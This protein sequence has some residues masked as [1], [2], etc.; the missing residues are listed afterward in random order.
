MSKY[1]DRKN[2][3][4]SQYVGY[5]AFADAT[6]RGQIRAAVDAGSTI[7]ANWDVMEG[8]LDYV[9]LK[10]GIDQEASLGGVGRPVVMTEP[11]ANLPYC[12]RMMNEL[13][14]ECYAAPSVAYGID[15][16]F[17]YRQ[18]SGRTGLV[19]SSS[20]S[21]THLIPVIDSRPLLGLSSRLNWGGAQASE[22]LLKLLKLKYPSFPD[23][24]T[25]VAAQNMVRE[26]CYVARDYDAELAG[27]L[28]WEGLEHR[29]RVVQYPYTEPVVVEKTPEELA[30]IAERKRESGRRL[31]EQ[32]AKM[33]LE[34][35]LKKERELEYYKELQGS[36]AGKPK[37]E[38]KRVLDAEDLRDEA[39]LDRVVYE[40][41][42]SIKRSRTR[43]LG[44]STGEDGGAAEGG[45]APG[46]EEGQEPTF[47]L[48]DTP[49]EE[50]DEAGVREKRH[51]PYGVNIVK[52][53]NRGW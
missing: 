19:L 17:A 1:R 42:R 9:F 53:N 45:G 14:F 23:K 46:S 25:D 51:Q 24:V 49:D 40:L 35:L 30:R 36:L 33:R 13:L 32:A 6:V 47:H 16:L 31:Q 41:E 10:L 27:F 44:S 26:H 50:L 18:N 48:L 22:Y 7:T 12:R 38:I 5:D 4:L 15:A 28:D 34:K 8:L 29:D 37:K 52:K 39:A 20:H 2:N 43:D 21:A 11:V 3:R